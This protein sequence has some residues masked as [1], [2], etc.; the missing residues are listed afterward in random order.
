[1]KLFTIALCLRGVSGKAAVQECASEDCSDQSALLQQP[2]VGL[3]RGKGKQGNAIQY[4]SSSST[5]S[6]SAKVGNRCAV[7]FTG[8]LRGLNQ[9]S[10]S[11]RR[12]LLEPIAS[13][14]VFVDVFVA[15]ARKGPFGITDFGI[16]SGDKSDASNSDPELLPRVAIQDFRWKSELSPK[17][18]QD[19]ITVSAP[20][21]ALAHYTKMPGVWLGPAFGQPGNGLR[22]Y[23]HEAECV[24]MIQQWEQAHEMK[25]KWV[26][27]TRTDFM[28]LAPHPPL[29]L[30]STNMVWTFDTEA[31][32]GVNDRHVVGGRDVMVSGVLSKMKMLAS[33]DPVVFKMHNGSSTSGWEQGDELFSKIVLDSQ[34]IHVGLMPTLAFLLECPSW[35]TFGWRP[36]MQSASEVPLSSK[37]AS[38]VNGAK[39]SAAQWEITNSYWAQ[40][41]RGKLGIQHK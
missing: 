9:T 38:E 18:L 29:S 12:Y 15:A 27:S 11:L 34:N 26:I 32:G 33:G 17:A 6:V 39:Q 21:E 28:W 37:Y 10:D 23:H 24:E 14:G 5:D 41:S 36:Y 4:S 7:C 31:F 3:E 22:I 25:Y 19:I 30:I 16:E 35:S 1:M 8:E 40:I 13:T 20:K 2:Q